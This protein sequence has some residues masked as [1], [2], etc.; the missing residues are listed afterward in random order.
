MLEGCY[1][2]NL[3]LR[4][5]E[6]KETSRLEISATSSR[7]PLGKMSSMGNR[8]SSVEIAAILITKPIKPNNKDVNYIMVS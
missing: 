2:E 4:F 8:E 6:S 3:P 7:A 1:W 5:S